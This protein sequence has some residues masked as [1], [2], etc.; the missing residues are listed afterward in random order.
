MDVSLARIL[1]CLFAGIGLIVLLT[2]KYRVHAFFALI[3]AC[4]IVGLGVGMPVDAVLTSVKDG[5]GNILKSLGLIIVLGTTLGAVLE[6]TGCTSVMANS[7]LKQIGSKRANLAMSLTGLIV[8]LPIFCDSGYIVLSGLN[9]SLARSSGIAM[10]VMATSLATGLYSVHCLI[11]PHPG[12]S[13]AAALIGV[14]YGRLIIT[15]T[16]VAIPAMLVGY[17]WAGYSGKKY[18]D[19]VTETEE[20]PTEPA[21]LPSALKAFLPVAIPILLI[22]VKAFFVI[23]TVAPNKWLTMFLSLGDPAIALAIGILLAFNAGSNWRKD[24]VAKLLQ[25]GAEKAG[26]ILVIIGAGGAFGAVL[27][28]TKIGGHLSAALPLASMG[29]FFPFLITFIIK[30]AQGSSTVAIITAASI[31]LPLLKP[32]GLDTATGH[33]L[34]VLAMG[35]GSMM[36]S[37][38]NDAYFWVIAKFSGLEMKTMLGVY[39]VSTVLMGLTSFAMVYL[40]SFIL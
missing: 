29:L 1:V 22:A 11:P 10:A 36:I 31:V 9:K 18:P 7:I 8:G 27:A 24:A 40:L 6:H 37:H 28:A 4:L 23:D 30:T 19:V 39:S 2:A 32:L 25:D 13:A 26:G 3:L 12:A 35:A 17:F 38:A 20:A 33:L 15:G 21:Y 16:L 5:F 14:D 34:G